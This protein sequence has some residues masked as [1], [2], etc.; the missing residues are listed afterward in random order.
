MNSARV[1]QLVRDNK[2]VLFPAFLFALL[3]I[4]TCLKISGTSIGVYHTYLYGENTKDPSLLFG[5]PQTVRSDEWL[6]NTQLTIAQEKNN[7]ERI[8][9]HFSEPKDMSLLFDAPYREWSAFFKPQNF[10]FFVLSVEYAFAFKWWVLLFALMTSVYFFCLKLLPN[11][12]LLAIAGSF[13]IGFSPF[14]FWWYQTGTIATLTYGFLITLV[15]M[16]L[17]DRTTIQVFGR[18]LSKKTS[19]IIKTSLLAY[20]LTAFALL[21][22]P[23]FQVPVSLVVF[24]FLLGYFIQ[25]SIGQPKKTTF[26]MA[27]PFLI[28]VIVTVGIGATYLTSRS[29]V[30]HAIGNTVYP[31]K[32]VVASGGYDVKKLLVS[33]LQP[34]LQQDEHGAKYDKN[35]S[36]SSNFI[37]LP[38]FL[39]IPSI[40]L[41]TWLYVKQKKFEWV[42]A[43]L[44]ACNLLFL[45]HLF[46]PSIDV[47]TKPFL[48]HL[49]PHDR[50]LIGL[51]F[52]AII[53]AL[54]MTKV[55]MDQKIVLTKK[56][57]WGAL[58][59]S[60]LF[61]GLMVW[62]GFETSKIY[63]DFI[64]SKKLIV[65]LAAALITGLSLILINKPRPGFLIIALFSI[66]SVLFI[67]PLYQGL[68]PLYNN[69]LTKTIET[70]SNKDATWAA[71]QS[72]Y[73]ENL[74][75][76]SGR[77]AVTGVAAYPSNKFWK[78]N[79]DMK[80]DHIYNR[81]AHVFLSANDSSSLVLIGTDLFAVSASCTRKVSQK[82]DYVIST[83]PLEGSCKKLIKTLHYPN[84]TFY[85]YKQ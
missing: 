20:L 73:I 66:A 40:V 57:L 8:N 35:Q 70:I 37:L 61:F 21:L 60:F 84:V 50:L 18:R 32:R 2:I 52:V 19:V 76:M 6:V 38:L 68:G 43:S 23:P 30:I 29:D 36:E 46:I 77:S 4:L 67:H 25:K 27:M 34:Q 83:T 31:G 11:K 55:Y 69:N 58:A 47:L 44:I 75:Q 63:P 16:S 26:S 42:L 22:Y 78:E 65:L 7:Y 79:S 1:K 17:I 85:F 81:Y 59:Y 51:G 41:V 9:P 71:A 56:Y 74:P 5:K 13:I 82:I 45:A 39:L 3:I 48:L 14:M 15:S 80:N 64:S 62:A 24:F 54:Y 49:V 53:T 12:I 28:A 72:I 33:Y 10:S